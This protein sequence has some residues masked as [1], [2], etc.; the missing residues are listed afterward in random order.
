MAF[1]DRGSNLKSQN[2]IELKTVNNHSG[3]KNCKKE[4]EKGEMKREV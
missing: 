2:L 3:P 4:R 1:T